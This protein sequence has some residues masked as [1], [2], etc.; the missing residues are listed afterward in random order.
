MDVH[1]QFDVDHEKTF[2]PYIADLLNDGF[3]VLIYAGDKDFTCDYLGNRAWTLQLEWKHGDDFQAAE[4][5][6][7]N[8]GGGLVRSSNG[9]T[10]LQV[11]DSGHLV[12]TDQPEKALAMITQFIRGELFSF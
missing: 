12:P 6:D 7:W 3:L 10:F 8:D 4:E 5:R 2:S 11:Y 1:A 9:F